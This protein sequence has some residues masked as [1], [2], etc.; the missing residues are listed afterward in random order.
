M[1]L[2][3]TLA[4]QAATVKQN[5]S[6]KEKLE[7]DYKIFF[8]QFPILSSI[9]VSFTYHNLLLTSAIMI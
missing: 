3:D 5:H 9:F 4:H 1:L 8:V 2:R 7:A 6:Q